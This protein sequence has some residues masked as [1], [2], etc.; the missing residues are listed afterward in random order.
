MNK[1]EFLIPFIFIGLSSAFLFISAMV[2]F[3]DGKSKKWVA[4][5]MKIGGLL[6]TLSFF[7]CG[8]SNYQK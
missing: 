4:R 1:K 8:N 6:L 5:K 7:S 3:S 2:Y